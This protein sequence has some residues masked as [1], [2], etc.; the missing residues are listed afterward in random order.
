[1]E[2]GAGEFIIPCDCNAGFQVIV[3]H[4]AGLGTGIS[5]KP[6]YQSKSLLSSPAP[7]S[8]LCKTGSQATCTCAH[9]DRL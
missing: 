2:T 7:V 4:V 6:A 1:M 9:F 3:V 5:W 8:M